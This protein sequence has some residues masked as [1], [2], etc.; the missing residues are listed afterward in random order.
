MFGFSKLELI[1]TPELILL[2]AKFVASD[3]KI[4]LKFFIQ[5]TFT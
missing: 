3:S 4:D 2:E 1:L 5:V